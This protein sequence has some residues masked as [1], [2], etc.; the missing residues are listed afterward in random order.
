MMKTEQKLTFQLFKNKEYRPSLQETQLNIILW[1]KIVGK[2]LT[3]RM[4]GC[5]IWKPYIN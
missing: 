4:Y 1:H 3:N 5:Q 2:I